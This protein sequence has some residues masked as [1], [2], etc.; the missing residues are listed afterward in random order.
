M[1]FLFRKNWEHV[2]CQYFHFSISVFRLIERRKKS[3]STIDTRATLRPFNFFTSNLTRPMP[4]LEG[5]EP[6]FLIF[7]VLISTFPQ[8]PY[9]LLEEEKYKGGQEIVKKKKVRRGKISGKSC[10]F[11]FFREKGKVRG[12]KFK[13]LGEPENDLDRSKVISM[14]FDEVKVSG[15][16]L[17]ENDMIPANI[18]FVI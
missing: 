9:I 15:L 17:Q 5:L 18:G 4:A 3:Y 16:V 7:R 6:P 8:T 10:A 12:R 11:F 1:H 2:L 13:A 14:N